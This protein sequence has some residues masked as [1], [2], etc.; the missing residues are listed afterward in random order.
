MFTSRRADRFKP[1]D[2]N[3]RLPVTPV[4]SSSREIRIDQA[5][6][7][8]D[9]GRQLAAI[10]EMVA[11]ISSAS[12]PETACKI[13]ADDLQDYLECREVIV[14]IKRHIRKPCTTVA[15]S[16]R[17]AVDAKHESTRLSDAVL[18]ECIVRDHIGYWP[19]TDSQNRHALLAHRQFAEYVSSAAMVSTPL[20]D[21]A[22]RA[23]GALL[24]IDNE[25][26]DESKASFVHAAEQ[27][28]SSA[29]GLQIR[30]AGNKVDRLMTR[31]NSQ[32]SGRKRQMFAAILI[33]IILLLCC[34]IRYRVACDCELQPVTRRYVA[35]P[36]GGRLEKH[37]VEPGDVVATGDML[38]RIDGRDVEWELSGKRAELHRVKKEHA[39][40]LVAHQSG[41]V[42]IASL[43]M[44]RLRLE[45]EQLED[46][47]ANLDIRSPIDGIVVLGD[48]S[49]SEG[50]PLEKGESLFEIAPLDQMLIEAFVP[51]D[52]IQ[53][54]SKGMTAQV[55]LDAFPTQKRTAAIQRI[56][57]RAELKDH[58]NVFIAE[59]TIDNTD[60]VL[61]PGM[62]GHAKLE[63]V[64]RSLGWVIFH[65]AYAATLVWF[66]W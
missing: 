3:T 30:S 55:R 25:P 11:R 15:V 58:E 53:F 5:K 49:K 66:G 2:T 42:E 46:H 54:I 8:K 44:E 45:I 51:E 40:Y 48:L 50:I 16:R 39:G 12:S 28:V 37:F 22:G 29:I 36:F 4:L 38:A 57:P 33:G 18:Q 35:A 7:P 20:R 17:D 56:H 27:P 10:A 47:A 26:I 24:I 6:A 52:D 23:H 61:R 21:M 14:G 9:S 62:Q 64:R 13:L 41:K 32:G 1:K 19:A 34:P 59:M 65:K 31:L 43:E 63:T 60:R